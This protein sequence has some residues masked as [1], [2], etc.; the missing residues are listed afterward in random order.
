M[1][2]YHIQK[3]N[4]LMNT[5]HFVSFYP[6]IFYTSARTCDNTEIGNEDAPGNYI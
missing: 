3:Y 4:F 6:D 2:V 1:Q 5:K